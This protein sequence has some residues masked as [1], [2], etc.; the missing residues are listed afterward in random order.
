M[1]FGDTK[2]GCLLPKVQKRILTD[3][4][5]LNKNLDELS[6]SGI[7]W[8]IDEENIQKIW[9]VITGQEG[10]PYANAPFLFEFTYPENYPLVPPQCKFCTS[11]GKTRFNPNLY[12]DGKICLSIL[13]TWSGPSWTPV[14]TTKTIIMS[15]IALVMTSEP[16]RNEPGWENSSS[17]DVEEYNLIVEYR[18]LKVAIIDQLNKCPLV[19]QPLFE[20]MLERFKKDYGTI[21]ARIKKNIGLRDGLDVKPRYGS[22]WK[23][24]YTDLKN[25]MEELGK[26][27]GLGLDEEVEVKR[28][29]EDPKIEIVEPPEKKPKTSASQYDLGYQM[30][31]DGLIYVVKENKNGKKFWRKMISTKN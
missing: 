6:E 18:S 7:Y 9:V 24:N 29:N 19:F 27:Y 4:S 20:K 13:G 8:H 15:I 26:K 1:S 3:I 30:E 25:E 12:V 2:K 17:L 31:L 14:M 28:P 5:E 23:L 11:D 21:I 22:Q 10:T 16:I